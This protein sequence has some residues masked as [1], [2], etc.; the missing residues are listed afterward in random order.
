[1][2]RQSTNGDLDEE[3]FQKRAVIFEFYTSPMAWLNTS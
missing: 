3:M 1:M 2:L